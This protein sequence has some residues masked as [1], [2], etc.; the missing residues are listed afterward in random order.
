MCAYFLMKSSALQLL[1]NVEK[2]KLGSSAE[3]ATLALPFG[4]RT[5]TIQGMSVDH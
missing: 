4:L 2:M 3:D 1:L 5:K